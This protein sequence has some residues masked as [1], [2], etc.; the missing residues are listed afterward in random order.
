MAS[1]DGKLSTNEG[2]G[3]RRP[4][5]QRNTANQGAL[6]SETVLGYLCMLCYNLALVDRK[7]D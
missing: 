6:Y 1:P 5:N 3:W 4:D 7:K 2:G